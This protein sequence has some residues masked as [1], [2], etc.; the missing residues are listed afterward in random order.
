[1]FSFIVVR[2]VIA[3]LLCISAIRSALSGTYLND[4]LSYHGFCHMFRFILKTLF[5]WDLFEGSIIIFLI[6]FSEYEVVGLDVY[7]GY[8]FQIFSTILKLYQYMEQ[9]LSEVVTDFCLNFR[10]FNKF[11]NRFTKIWVPVK[12]NTFREW[13]ALSLWALI[14]PQIFEN[15]LLNVIGHLKFKEISVNASE[16]FFSMY[17]YKVP[18]HL[19]NFYDSDLKYTFES[20][21]QF[22][23]R[24]IDNLKYRRRIIL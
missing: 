1:M 18:M 21:T 3:L 4:I 11:H 13:D 5:N 8:F 16:K 10:G 19:D 24:H 2:D 6:S 7:F 22:T 17:W 20:T 12:V 15:R 14:E 9:N 23:L